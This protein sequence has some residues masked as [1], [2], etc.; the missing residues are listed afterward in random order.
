VGTIVGSVTG[1]IGSFA[2]V[3]FAWKSYKLKKEEK[4]KDTSEGQP[5]AVGT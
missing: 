3:Y 1:A 4:K 2:G 5:K